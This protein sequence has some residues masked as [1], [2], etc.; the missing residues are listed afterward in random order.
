[1]ASSAVYAV[2]EVKKNMTK[3]EKDARD[4]KKPRRG[5]RGVHQDPLGGQAEGRQQEDLALK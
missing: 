3:S 5:L 2:T 4:A 1:M